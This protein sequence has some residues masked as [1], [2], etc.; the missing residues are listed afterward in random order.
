MGIGKE[1]SR[2]EKGSCI[3]YSM[4]IKLMNFLKNSVEIDLDINNLLY[5]DITILS[6]DEI[7]EVFYPSES[8]KYDISDLLG[9]SRSMNCFEGRH[10]LYIKNKLNLIDKFN[11]RSNI[12]ERW[13]E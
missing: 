8:K 4:K 5:A 7:L 11:L 1:Y 2:K 9:L 10:T 6:G 12:N 13:Y 3:E